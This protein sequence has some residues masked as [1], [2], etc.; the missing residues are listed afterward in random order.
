MATLTA[1]AAGDTLVEKETAYTSTATYYKAT[2]ASIEK[3]GTTLSFSISLAITLGSKTSIGKGSGKTRT[4]YVYSGNKLL[5][6]KL[7]KDANTTWGQGSSHTCTISCKTTVSGAAGTLKDCYIRILYSTTSDYG[8]G[9]TTD[10]TESCYWNGSK[11]TNGG[12]AGNTFNI[13]HAK[14]TYKLTLKP[15]TGVASFSGGGTYIAGTDAETIAK[16]STGY[17]L[18]S[19]SG[20]T[21]DGEGTDSWTTC[22]GEKSHTQAWTMKANRTITCNAAKDTYLIDYKGNGSTGGKTDSHYKTYNEDL[23]LQS[24]GFTRDKKSANPY[25]ITYKG[26]GGTPGRASDSVACTT[27]YTFKNWNTAANGSGTSYAAK[28]KYTTNAAATLYAQWNSS[29]SASTSVTLPSASRS[30]G[31]VTGYKV[32]FNANGGSC[33][34]SD[35]TSTRTTSFT[36]KGW[37][38]SSTATSG[39]T[40]SYRPTGNVTLYATW[41]TSYTNNA[42]T[43]PPASRNGYTFKGWSTSDNATT[44]TTGSYTP[45]K[46][47]TLYAV[48]ELNGFAVTLKSGTGISTVSGAGTYY[49]GTSVVINATVSD[50][51]TFNGWTGTYSSKDSQYSFSMPDKNVNCTANATESTYTVTLNAYGGHFGSDTSVKTKPVSVTYNKPYGELPEPDREEHEFAGWF[52]TDGDNPAEVGVQITKDSIVKITDN[53]TILYAHWYD[54]DLD[55]AYLNSFVK[56]KRKRT[57]NF[58]ATVTKRFS[59]YKVLG[60][61]INKILTDTSLSDEK[62][63]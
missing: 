19:Y 24:N 28:A 7:I 8:K 2:L 61:D 41:Q 42:I 37:S 14:Y 50:G 25:T 54:A 45:N 46:N 11:E 51:Y 10:F 36:F 58:N 44:G 26:N 38:T 6:S 49:P 55:K 15:G 22:K 12:S 17:H 20:T 18:T 35:L 40:G 16:A 47:I 62:K 5:C 32:T 27:S 3:T 34:T 63:T 48:W 21:Y 23:D 1:K 56:T 43:L 29:T 57:N 52:T 30:K 33:S 53:D 39:S 9:E 59:T 4:A 13:S 31:S 60:E